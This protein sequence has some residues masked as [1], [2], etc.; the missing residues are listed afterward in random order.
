MT[1]TSRR[2]RLFE[3][4]DDANIVEVAP[5]HLRLT[6]GVGNPCASFGSVSLSPRFG[7][8]VSETLGEIWVKALQET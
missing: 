4:I 3:K 7:G 1:L 2:L 8:G 5:V 6:P